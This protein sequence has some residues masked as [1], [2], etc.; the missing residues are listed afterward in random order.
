MQRMGVLEPHTP[1]LGPSANIYSNV[2]LGKSLSLFQSISLNKGENKTYQ[3]V[4]GGLEIISFYISSTRIV[5]TQEMVVLFIMTALPT[6]FCDRSLESNNLTQNEYQ[7]FPEE[8]RKCNFAYPLTLGPYQIQ[9]ILI[10]FALQWRH[11]TLTFNLHTLNHMF[12]ENNSHSNHSSHKTW[13]QMQANYFI[14]CS[15]SRDVF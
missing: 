5:N 15:R 10:P 11:I 1:S 6:L 7:A 12:A 14:C 13:P 3:R 9:T 8:G 4:M 2:T